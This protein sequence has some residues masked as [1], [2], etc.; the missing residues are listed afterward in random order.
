MTQVGVATLSVIQ[1]T[2]VSPFQVATFRISVA[3]SLQAGPVH[4]E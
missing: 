2:R 1:A 4:G 3:P